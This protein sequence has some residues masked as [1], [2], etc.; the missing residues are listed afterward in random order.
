MLELELRI[1]LKA[2]KA[3]KVI[4][5]VSTAMKKTIVVKVQRRFKHPFFGKIISRSK[6][7]KVHD[8]T[9]SAQNGD[10]VEIAEC[11]PL[12]KTKHMFIYRIIKRGN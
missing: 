7:Y 4:V 1:K 2:K 6:K 10:M 11:R 3:H 12:S 9:D 8:E 5:V